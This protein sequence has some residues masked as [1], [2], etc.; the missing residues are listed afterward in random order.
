[1]KSN[2]RLANGYLRFRKCLPGAILACLVLVEVVSLWAAEDTNTLEIQSISVNG[3]SLSFQGKESVSLGSSPENIIFSFGPGTNAGKPPLRLRY[4][5]EGYENIWHE[6]ST[7]MGMNVRFYNSSGDQISRHI[8]PVSGET[9]GWTGSLRNSLLTHRRETLVVPPQ[10]ARLVIVISSAGPPDSVGIYVVANLVVSKSSGSQG[11]VI[12]L[13][14][15]FDNDNRD[16]AGDDPPAGW[17]HDGTRPSMARVVKFGQDPQIKAFAIVDE[18]P[19]SHAEW[20]NIVDSAPAVKPGDNLVVEWNEMY[21]IGSG[22]IYEATYGRLPSGHYKF[23]VR[24]LNV[25]GMLTGGEASVN[26]FVAQPFWK[27]SWFW[28]VAAIA[29][30]A[31]IIGIS[32][33]FVWHKMRREMARLK[34]QR[35]LEQERLRIAHDIHDDLGARVTQISLLSAMAQENPAF[36]DKARADFDKVS[37]MSRELV[38]ALYETVWAVNPENDN[39]DALG[40][41][42]C[43]MVKQL[44]ERTPLRCRFHV[45]DLPHEIQVSSQTRHNISLAVKEAVHNILKHAKASEVTMR[46]VF[47]DGELDVSIHDDGSS[48]QP[49][50]NLSGHGLS[51]MRQRLQK[52]GG[53]C[54]VDGNPGHGTTVRMR[55]RIQPPVQGS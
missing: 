11:N 44:C 8:Y 34:E 49:A 26:V 29:A 45:L 52:I 3:K 5:L 22:G 28:G 21:S 50:D 46:I 31:M 7:D 2:L 36:P 38:S 16:L 48:F 41:Y 6:M 55:L 37:K 10:A 35:A 14:S 53:Q 17:V 23:R 4:M 30:T 42:L 47:T 24:G 18:D 15:P 32:R 40:N 51:N 19:V 1:M 12:L 20:H 54:F 33:Y 43:Q 39:L 27:T 13:Q 25:M 9:T